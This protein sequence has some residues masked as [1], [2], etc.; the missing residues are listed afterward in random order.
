[1]SPN[2]PLRIG[3]ACLP[4]I[5][6][7][8]ILATSLGRELA[9]RG[10][11]VLVFSPTAPSR[12]DP[13]LPG[14]HFR[15]VQS[16]PGGHSFPPSDYAPELAAAILEE[17]RRA[18][19]DALH[20][21]YGFPHARGIVLAAA[22]MPEHR[23]ILATTLHGSDVARLAR[24]PV[25]RLAL[26]ACDV[27]TTV[28]AWQRREAIA[29][30]RPGRPIEV[31]PNFFTPAPATRSRAEVRAEL[32]LREDEFLAVHMSNVRPV[33]RIDLLLRMLR[34]TRPG[35]RLLLMAGGDFSPYAHLV[36]ELGLED[37]VILRFDVAR[38]EDLLPAADCGLSTSE[39]ESFGLSILETQFHGLPVLAF[40]VG[41]IPGVVADARQL[42]P[43]GDVDGMA[44]RLEQWADDA[45]L[46]RTLGEKAK[47]HVEAHFTADQVVPDY[48][49][50]YRPVADA[51][52]ASAA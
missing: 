1:M 50:C 51:R 26:D 13:H 8:G 24:E 47:A 18:P 17:S 27:V 11:E 48:E 35:I 32:G 36:Q 45:A 25:H 49:R 46:A 22:Q 42:L 21:H 41:G 23:P 10:H 30:L 5:G 20:A 6:G 44:A 4:R 19:F 52:A 39:Q 34:Q 37:R 15:A 29:Q 43:F 31:I 33:K 7:S 9:L 2:K 28:S 16:G 12:F 14:L 38:V 3:I 40:A